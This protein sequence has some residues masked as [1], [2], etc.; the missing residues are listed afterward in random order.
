MDISLNKQK[1]ETDYWKKLLDDMTFKMNEIKI[2][3]SNR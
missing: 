2:F 3:K 1:K